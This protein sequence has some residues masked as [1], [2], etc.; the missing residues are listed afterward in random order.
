[1]CVLGLGFIVL[2]LIEF[3]Q[4][5]EF[6]N[7]PTSESVGF[8]YENVPR[9]SRIV[10]SIKIMLFSTKTSNHIFANPQ[11][12]SLFGGIGMGKMCSSIEND[13]RK[14]FDYQANKPF[15]CLRNK[16]FER[17]KEIKRVFV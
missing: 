5:K 11:A 1:M 10:Q 17:V 6:Y 15:E 2:F 13:V 7:N 14:G 9:F 3:K 16:K 8:F 12:S 4:I